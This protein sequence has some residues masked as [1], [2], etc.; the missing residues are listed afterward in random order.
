MSVINRKPYIE[1][2]LE[3]LSA[4]NLAT[5]KSLINGSANAIFRSF[6]NKDC[7]MTADDAGIKHLVL[8][9]K[10]A[11]FTGYLIFTDDYCVLFSYDGLSQEMRIVDIDYEKK[12]Y[13][14]I[15][16]ELSI[17]E[18]RRVL[19]D[20]T[21]SQGGKPVKDL[22]AETVLAED[23][24]EIGASGVVGDNL[25]AK[26][27]TKYVIKMTAPANPNSL[28]DGEVAKIIK[29][30]FIEGTFLNFVN[31]VLFPATERTNDYVGLIIGQDDTNGLTTLCQYRLYKSDKKIIAIDDY[32]LVFNR[33][34]NQLQIVGNIAI[35][36]KLLADI[37]N[38]AATK[39]YVPK[40]VNGTWTFVEEE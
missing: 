2:V 16:E 3:T 38:D 11:I 10:D 6:I 1:T 23:E 34:G 33:G 20:T 30:C 40:L 21:E 25:L 19:D 13:E 8:E 24:L 31:P 29:G 39:T 9:T 17:N 22:V 14:I 7:P 28:A 12:E 36:G 18:L 37:P 5:L 4:A 35:K 26:L 15:K 27:G 32:K